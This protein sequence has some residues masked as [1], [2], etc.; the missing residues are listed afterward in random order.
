MIKKE[1]ILIKMYD[2]KYL[3]FDRKIKILE[4]L[5]I[6]FLKCTI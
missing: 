5:C 3:V 4:A 1:L 6:Q 2:I